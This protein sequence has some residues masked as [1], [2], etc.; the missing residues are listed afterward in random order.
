MFKYK[1]LKKNEQEKKVEVSETINDEDVTPSF[2]PDEETSYIESPKEPI[3]VR[4]EELIKMAR[5]KR[6]FTILQRERAM[7]E[8][9]RG[10]NRSAV[11][12]GLCILGTIVSIY[13]N[14][15]DIHQ[16]I[17]HE[18][19]SFYSWE[20][21]DQYIQDL[22]PLT[23]LLIAGSGGFISNYLRHSRRLKKAQQELEDFNASLENNS[24]EELGGNENVRK[25]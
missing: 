14:D 12:A 17:Q 21:F 4:D 3:I 10:K 15:Q 18:L 23:T 13:F 6:R 16:V 22:G 25:R 5:E 11:M 19:N 1:K 2:A 9:Q 7:D 24:V 20:A 8:A